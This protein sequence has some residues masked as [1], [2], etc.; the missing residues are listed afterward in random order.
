MMLE[1]DRRSGQNG[2]IALFK[3]SY[4]HIYGLWAFIE[5]VGCTVHFTMVEQKRIPP[6]RALE[7]ATGE[8]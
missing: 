4:V 2:L 8:Q 7:H 3:Q 1:R 6:C 5:E